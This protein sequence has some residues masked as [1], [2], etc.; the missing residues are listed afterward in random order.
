MWGG[1]QMG[2]FL[3]GGWFHV[4]WCFGWVVSRGVVSW[5]GGF[6]WAGVLVGWRMWA[7]VLVSCGL[8]S[9]WGGVQ[10][11]W[12]LGVVMFSYAGVLV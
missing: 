11:C 9:W 4:G 1:G 6:M 12:C 8:V 5:W 7:G 10:L 2:W 3:G